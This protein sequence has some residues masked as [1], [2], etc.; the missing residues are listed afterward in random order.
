ML[1]IGAGHGRWSVLLEKHAGT[2]IL[3]DLSPNCIEFC[4]NLFV[5]RS[6]VIYVVN[7]GKTF[8]V[9]KDVS[10]D[11]IWSFDTFVHVEEVVINSY[12]KEIFRVLKP[13]GRAIIHHPDRN[14]YLLWMGFIRHLGV[15]GNRFYRFISMHRIKDTDGWRSNISK[16]MIRSLV[17]K[18]G[19]TVIDQLQFWDQKEKIGVPRFND[20]I[21]IIQ[22]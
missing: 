13:G 21:T 9:V 6:N 20:Y 11:F 15:R 14:H 16:Q 7:N 2:L 17:L 18:H 1:E 3:V 12:M 19:L 5:K 8:D 22:K 4:R 10:V